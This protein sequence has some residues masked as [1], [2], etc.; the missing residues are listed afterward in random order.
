MYFL[1]SS[2]LNPG[3]FHTYVNIFTCKL[4]NTSTIFKL[5]VITLWPMCVWER[6]GLHFSR[7][8]AWCYEGNPSILAFSRAIIGGY[9]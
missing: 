1:K 9:R 3:S 2:N 5:L 6:G 4:I 7:Q 8:L